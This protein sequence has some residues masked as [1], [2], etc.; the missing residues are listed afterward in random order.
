MHTQQRFVTLALWLTLTLFAATSP[1][2]G[3]PV[4]PTPEG[5]DQFAVFMAT[6]V[7]DPTSPNPDPEITGCSFMFCDAPY[8][9]EVVMGWNP[10]EIAAEEAAARLFFWERFGIDVDDLVA[11]GRINFLPFSIDPRIE[12]RVYH[13]AG[14][15]VPAG[16]WEVRDGGFLVIVV[17]P[18]GIE[19]G[20]EF[21]GERAMAGSS[22]AIGAYNILTTRP[23]GQPGEEIVIRYKTPGPSVPVDGP[24]GFVCEIEEEAWG[25]GLA[26]GFIFHVP[27]PDGRLRFNIRNVLT[28][29]GPGF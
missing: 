19:L 12:Y 17:D 13:M 28:F 14:F 8:F 23:N 10:T 9:Q 3:A 21:A 24:I 20:G 26:Q 25:S 2:T 18:E 5:F 11:S 6:G 7:F 4:P 1:A 15:R 22:M 27:Q 29:P 16:G